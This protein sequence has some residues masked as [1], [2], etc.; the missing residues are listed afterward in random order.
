[1]TDEQTNVDNSDLASNM[2]D[3]EQRASEKG[4]V[5]ENE[6]EGDPNQW[7]PAKEFLDRGELMDRISSQSRQIEKY[8]S[9]VSEM[10]T[11]M[12]ELANHN[13]KIA[14]QEYKKAMAD[15][16]SQKVQALDSMD[17]TAVADIDEQISDLKQSKKE[18]EEEA[19]QESSQQ[20]SNTP[21]PDFLN[22]V[23]QNTWY[24]NDI[25]LQGAA[26]AI[27]KQYM[28]KNPG[29]ESNPAEVLR[30]VTEQVTNEFPDRFGNKTKRRPSATTESS[31][32][33]TTRTKGKTKYSMKDLTPEQKSIAKRFA[34]TGIMT[35]QDYVDQLAELGELG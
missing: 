12:K 30:Y 29:V 20:D 35:E 17:H 21:H 26:D 27:A 32:T 22:W 24:Q 34:S 3:H 23:E 16:K 33:G 13:K 2:T 9:E 14:E 8:N 25:V 7:R 31:T 1:M 6:W 11:A 18:A 15:L 19:V 10:K 28:S 4:W 5:P